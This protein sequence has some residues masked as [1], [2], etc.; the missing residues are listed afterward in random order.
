M[1]ESLVAISW[2][3]SEITRWK[4]RRTKRQQQNNGLYFYREG[5]HK[6]IRSLLGYV[7]GRVSAKPVGLE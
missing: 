6:M 5:G 7:Y 1:C 2:A 4:K 3:I